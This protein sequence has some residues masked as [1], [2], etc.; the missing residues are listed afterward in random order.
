MAKAKAAAPAKGAAPAKAP[1][2]GAKKAAGK[3]ALT[4]AQFVAH[5]AEKTELTKKQIDTVLEE[6]VTTIT[7]QLKSSG[8][9]VFPGLA[10]MSLT[11]VAA[12]AGGEEK[13]NPLNKEKYITK[14]RP[15]FNKVNIRPI[16]AIKTALA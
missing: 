4:K 13:I 15:A 9:F 16:K 10:R 7:D 8:K 12:R 2:K 6:I 1:A 11:Q 5:L 14:P 3:K